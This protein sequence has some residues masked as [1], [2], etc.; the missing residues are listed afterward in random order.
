M[1]A[2]QIKRL[3]DEYAEALSSDNA[4]HFPEGAS[5][6]LRKR[7][8]AAIDAALPGVPLSER[9]IHGGPNAG[10]V[11][12]EFAHTA[13]PP[14]FGENYAGQGAAPNEP[15]AP[16]PSADL[17]WLV[18]NYVEFCIRL[19]KLQDGTPEYDQ[20]L[21]VCET[22]WQK[23]NAALAE[24]ASPQAVPAEFCWLVELFEPGGNSLGAYH[25]GFSDTSWQSRSTKDPHQARRYNS[26]E[27]A[28]RAASEL[29]SKAGVWRAVEHGFVAAPQAVDVAA[30]PPAPQGIKRERTYCHKG[31]TWTTATH[32]PCSRR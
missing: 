1:R 26:K 8:H 24:R 17:R 10:R 27:E 25:T 14:P 31:L 2:E 11:K 16:L 15:V 23:I 30:Q 4:G 32:K 13:E 22:A 20:Q 7:L 5:R 19:D 18:N 6:P 12:R 28:E 29:F 3:A 9:L 21:G